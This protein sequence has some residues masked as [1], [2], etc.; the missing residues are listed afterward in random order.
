MDDKNDHPW[1]SRNVGG[2]ILDS[3]SRDSERYKVADDFW[4]GQEKEGHQVCLLELFPEALP[5][6]KAYAPSPTRLPLSCLL[7]TA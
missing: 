4:E 2:V 6:P 7:S 3:F 1:D 5:E